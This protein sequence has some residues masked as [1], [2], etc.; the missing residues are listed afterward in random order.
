MPVLDELGLQVDHE[1]IESIDANALVADHNVLILDAICS[2]FFHNLHVAVADVELV[3]PVYKVL[4][5]S[6]RV[7]NVDREK[8][9]TKLL[10]LLVCQ[11]KELSL[12]GDD[13]L[14]LGD[15]LLIVEVDF[16]SF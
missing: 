3:V 8:V 16:S 2:C 14:D 13:V 1:D 7:G 4:R 12:V 10:V 5:L 9:V 6:L 15:V 11:D